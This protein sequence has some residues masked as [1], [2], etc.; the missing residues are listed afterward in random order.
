MPDAA[1]YEYPSPLAGYEDAPPLPDERAADGKS[2]ANP[3]NDKLSKAYEEFTNPL[4]N[5]R[6]GGL[7]VDC[8]PLSVRERD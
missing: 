6:R 8:L 2:F 4:D 7:S 3:P 5:G 1:Q